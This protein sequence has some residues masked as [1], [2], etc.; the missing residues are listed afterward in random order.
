NVVENVMMG[1]LF[2]RE[3]TLSLKQAKEAALEIIDYTA[4][5]SKAYAPAAELSLAEQRRLELARAMA[6]RPK[7]LLLDEVMA[8]LNPS[9]ISD[10]LD[11]LR[12][13]NAEKNISILVIEH[14]VKAVMRLCSRIVVMDYGSKLAEGTPDEI[15]TNV[16]VIQAYM[17]E[18]RTGKKNSASVR[19]ESSTSSDLVDSE[20]QV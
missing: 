2:G 11:L 3:R 15:A 20:K 16:K 8:G 14:V 18:K 17:G 12:R 10:T 7:L 13:L 6:T 1:R 19:S 5:T 4:L 9:E